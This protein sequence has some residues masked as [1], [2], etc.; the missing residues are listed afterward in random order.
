MEIGAEFVLE[1]VWEAC[2][3]ILENNEF[4][5][6]RHPANIGYFTS[7]AAECSSRSHFGSCVQS[8]Q[9]KTLCSDGGGDSSPHILANHVHAD[10][11]AKVE[12]AGVLGTVVLGLQ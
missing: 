1:W 2:F 3:A 4:G 8:S 6:S 10:I 11:R 9:E 7:V 12:V 5:A